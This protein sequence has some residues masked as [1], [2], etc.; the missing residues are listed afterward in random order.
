MARCAWSG[1]LLPVAL[2]GGACGEGE[3]PERALSIV[4]SADP[5]G[6]ADGGA[7]GADGGGDDTAGP[8]PAYPSAYCGGGDAAPVWPEGGLTLDGCARLTPEESDPVPQGGSDTPPAGPP[9]ACAAPPPSGEA[10][11]PCGYFNLVGAVQMSAAAEPVVLYCDADIEGGVRSARY[12]AATGAVQSVMLQ[13]EQCLAEADAGTL[14]RGADALLA[15]WIAPDATEGG[16]VEPG[17]FVANLDD[18]GALLGP[19]ERL[20]FPGWPV[21]VEAAAE[22]SPLLIVEDHDNLLWAVPVAADGNVTGEPVQIASAIRMYAVTGHGDGLAVAVCMLDTSLQVFVVDSAGVVTRSLSVEG[23]ACTFDTRPSVASDG[24]ALVVGWDD[25][26]EGSLAWVDS[27]SDTVVTAALGE[28]S[29]FP[30]AAYDGAQWWSIDGTGALQ[31]WSAPGASERS[32]LHPAIAAMPGKIA[33]LR[34]KV[35]GGVAGFLTLATDSI[36]VAQGHIYTFYYLESSRAL[37]PE[38]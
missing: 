2:L 34:F 12:D 33:N 21:R 23:A 1:I 10:P 9:P 31:R 24:V 28:G 3:A 30:Q 11:P 19:P 16:D 36:Q 15:W 4:D 18:T 17:I 29:R 5:N 26:T 8:S 6:G 35:E 27:A 25:A 14:S 20:Y 13:S 7:D 22:A 32:F 38:G 37:L